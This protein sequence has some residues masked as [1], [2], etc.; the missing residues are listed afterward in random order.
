[1]IPS[2]LPI[3][4]VTNLD[5]MRQRLTKDCFRG[6]LWTPSRDAD[7]DRFL[8]LV[9]RAT[10]ACAVT[11]FAPGGGMTLADWA[12]CVLG[13]PADFTL[14]MVES[15][16]IRLRHVMTLVQVER[17][18][19]ATESGVE[20][21]IRIDGHGTYFFVATGKMHNPVMIGAVNRL[22]S[23]WNEMLIPLDYTGVWLEG[24]RLLVPN[25]TAPK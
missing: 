1:M 19:E 11:A 18:A 14:S 12:R 23:I 22:P 24:Y 17:L 15:S 6:Q 4:A 20:T 25:Y 5:G 7:L 3:V 9:Q 13:K 21:G 10:S 16:L 8:P 2:P